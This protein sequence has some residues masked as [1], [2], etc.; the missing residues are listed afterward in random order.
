MKKNFNSK[1]KKKIIQ[2]VK[3]N[4]LYFYLGIRSLIEKIFGFK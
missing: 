1:E 4:F 3:L 2:Q